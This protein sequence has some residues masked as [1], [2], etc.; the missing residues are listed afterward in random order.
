MH[1]YSRSTNSARKGGKRKPLQA[2]PRVPRWSRHGRSPLRTF[3]FLQFLPSPSPSPSVVSLLCCLRPFTVH[4]SPDHHPDRD[5]RRKPRGRRPPHLLASGDRPEVNIPSSIV[6]WPLGCLHL[7]DSAL[8]LIPPTRLGQFRSSQF[9][10][11]VAKVVP[12]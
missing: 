11:V 5:C 3:P 4:T 12:I 2:I 9:C 6:L 10:R 1:S 8:P 7:S